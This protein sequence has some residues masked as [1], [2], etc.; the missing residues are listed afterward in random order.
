MPIG[1]AASTVVTVRG[2]AEPVPVVRERLL[3]R[4]AEATVVLVEASGGFG[5]SFFAA[6]LASSRDAPRPRVVVDDAG[7]LWS[8]LG[9]ALHRRGLADLVA[10]VRPDDPFVFAS[11]LAARGGGVVL[12][13]DEVQRASPDEGAWLLRLAQTVAAPTMLVIVGRRLG[14]VLADLA[15][16]DE[17]LLITTTDLRFDRNETAAALAGSGPLGA[18]EIDAVYALTD[19]WPAA[20]AL[21]GARLAVGGHLPAAAGSASLVE[22]IDRQLASCPPRTVALAREL[23]HLPLLSAEVA[24]RVGGDGS[25]D[26]VLDLGL[27]VR[28]R[29][30]G[31]GEMADP[32]R[33]H[34]TADHHPQLVNIR[35]A[36]DVYAR[37]NE[38]P[39]AGLL[40]ARH[41][42]QDGLL[43][44]IGRW[45]W[46]Q[47]AGIGLPTVEVLL[48]AIS[49]E[50]LAP[51]SMVLVRAAL[52]AD[53]T[54][55]ARRAT[56]IARALRI[57]AD[58]VVLRAAQ[59]EV[60]RDLGRQHEMAA[61]FQALES[62]LAAASAD[63][64]V[65]R[66]RALL[67]LGVSHLVVEQ[68]RASTRSIDELE[69]AS[70][71]FRA[72]GERS[73]E[74][75]ALRA[76]A[77]GAHFNLGAFDCAAD[78]MTR[79]AALL[80]APDA[81]RSLFLTFVAEIDRDRG[82]LDAAETALHE[83]LAIARRVGITQA[84]GYA[85]WG[86]A[87]VAG[88][89]RDRAGVARWCAETLA[90]GAG[91]LERGA[92]VDYYAMVGEVLLQ[93]GDA[94]AGLTHVEAAEQHPAAGGYVWPARSARAR[95]EAMFG[96][97]VV[98]E[99]VLD[100]LDLIAPI[101][102]LALRALT[103]AVCAARR[104][105]PE[106]AGAELARAEQASRDLGDPDRLRRREPEMLAM[107]HDDTT[108]PAP[109]AVSM[110]L[111][112]DFVVQRG[113]LVVTPPAGRAATLVKVLALR[114]GI[115]T[116][117]VIDLL[118]DDCDV[119]TGRARLRNLLNR[120][121]TSSGALVERDGDLLRL[122]VGTEVDVAR[123]EQA[124]IS[125][126]DGDVAGRVGAARGALAAWGGDLLP[127]DPYDDWSVGHRERLRRRHLALVDLVAHDAMDRGDLDEAVHLFELGIESEPFEL[128]RHTLVARSLVTQG[129]SRSATEVARRA[130]EVAQDLGVEIDGFMR[131]LLRE[132]DA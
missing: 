111:L 74:A 112:G 86:M 47:L 66:G 7:D 9:H 125:A 22:L 94:D 95:Y 102:E 40:L 69:Q 14:R 39:T 32:V 100:E 107:L 3:A 57:A 78:Q 16:D 42:D 28:F 123:F 88:E 64:L 41:R 23:A 44:L 63:E 17:A 70:A 31:W 10:S 75:T 15:R 45:S 82:H 13:V 33:D 65:T 43:A 26:V 19:G 52:A 114:G 53:E 80:A 4:A 113:A 116:D 35:A 115:T 101:R 90:H 51:Q 85:A 27:P 46:Q 56:W 73:Y 67:A 12:T 122:A 109:G 8:S 37:R 5:K 127:G 76:S 108:A 118:W 29:Y 61:A 2:R 93:L 120:I 131:E 97:P 62:A 87:L 50:V 60:G 20:V 92:G 128:W 130:R 119:D 58:P 48:D 6:Q 91:W 36:A 59:V 77:F 25:L 54:D 98:A 84:I 68:G 24:E 124:A 103:R 55:T 30:D 110:R 129:R 83:S 96:D 89:R 106:R 104:G 132:S 11:A 49:D 1:R 21:A 38:A 34:L 72:A 126:L 79:A 99:A 117:A 71:L 105:D 81:T 121:R 18:D